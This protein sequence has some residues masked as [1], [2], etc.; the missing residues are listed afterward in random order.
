MKDNEYKDVF[1]ALKYYNISI[2][3]KDDITSVKI[4]DTD[5][6]NLDSED[7]D[8]TVEFE[9]IVKYENADGDDKKEYL[10]LVTE[11]LDGDVDDTDY[12]LT[13]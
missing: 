4:D 1:N 2:V 7:E 13:L 8:A 9:L 6:D 5:I 3:S 10:T 12:T 11:I